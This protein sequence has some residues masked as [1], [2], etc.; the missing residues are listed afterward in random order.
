M[1]RFVLWVFDSS[2]GMEIHGVG[3]TE[4]GAREDAC[5][6]CY[7]PGSEEPEEAAEQLRTGGRPVYLLIAP[8]A[9]EGILRPLYPGVADRVKRMIELS[10]LTCD[11][12]VQVIEARAN[13]APSPF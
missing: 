5:L 10:A 11:Q 13:H 9:L 3:Y 7:G 12:L 1:Q 6:A 2:I 8:R 4:D